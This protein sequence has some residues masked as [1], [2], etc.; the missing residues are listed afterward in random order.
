ML[1]VLEKT[2]KDFGTLLGWAIAITVNII[3]QN[4]DFQ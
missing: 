2:K 1:N 3:Q 4:V